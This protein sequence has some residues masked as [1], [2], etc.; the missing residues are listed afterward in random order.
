MAG[1]YGSALRS[2][3]DLA[4]VFDYDG[5]T[6]YFYLYR[7]FDDQ[8]GEVLDAIHVFSGK[9]DLKKGDIHITWDRKEK[10]VGLF[11]RGGLWA[12]YSEPW[13]TRHGGNYAPGK[14]SS[15]KLNFE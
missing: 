4:G 8:S 11:I 7:P 3:G 10:Q 2:S 6:A 1:I 9:L 12:A 14:P 13:P 15:L 5:E